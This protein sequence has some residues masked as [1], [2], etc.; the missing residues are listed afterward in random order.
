MNRVFIGVDSRQPIAYN[1]LQWSIHVHAKKPVIVQPLII[2]QL[3]VVRRGLTEFTFTRYL[4]PYLCGFEGFAIFMDADMLVLEDINELFDSFDDPDGPA[5]R[6]MKD[7][8]AFEWPSLMY[9]NNHKCDQL[10]P[11]YINDERTKPNGLEWA[12]GIGTLPHR[13]NVMTR[14]SVDDDIPDNAAVLHFTEGLPCFYET[15]N[16]IGADDWKSAQKQMNGTV[17]WEK[18]MGGSIHAEPVLRRMLAEY[19]GGGNVIR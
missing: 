2:D 17:T 9:F 12:R 14:A 11:G 6:V 3:P 18:L 10:T 13:W 1:V 19:K 8:P 15:R 7:Q 16:T 5:V 4:A